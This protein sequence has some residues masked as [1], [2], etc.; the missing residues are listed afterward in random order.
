MKQVQGVKLEEKGLTIFSDKRRAK[1]HPE[2]RT[3]CKLI[4][5]AESA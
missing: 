4:A 2:V 3:I 1:I 5:D